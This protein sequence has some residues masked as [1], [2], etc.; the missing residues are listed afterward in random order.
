MFRGWV[1]S[2]YSFLKVRPRIR[3]RVLWVL[4]VL[5]RASHI[6]VRPLGTRYPAPGLAP[7]TDRWAE[8]TSAKGFAI[9]QVREGESVVNE[10]PKGLPRAIDSEFLLGANVEVPPSY[11]LTLPQGRVVGAHGAVVT[12]DNF[13]LQDLSWPVSMLRTSLLRE[14]DEIPEP[15]EF[16]RDSALPPRHLPGR[17][18]V[19]ST[20]FGRT[21]FHWMFDVI[22][23]LGVLQDAGIE[24]DSI[25]TFVVP[26][27]FSG[28]HHETLKSVGITRSRIVSSLRNRHVQADLLLA[29]S[30]T[31]RNGVVPSWV[32]D[33][34]R[35]LFPPS[36]P[37]HRD[38]PTRIYITRKLT[39]HGLLQGEEELV[40]RLAQHG[41]RPV[42]MEDYSL[43][44]KAWLLGR[45]EAV[46]GPSG[47][48]L[49]NIVFCS[50][51]TKVVELR[52]QPIP[53]MEPWDIANRC[54]I[55]F[56]EV[57]PKGYRSGSGQ[58]EVDK[59]GFAAQGEV[60]SEELFQTLEMADLLGTGSRR[61]D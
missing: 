20:F 48:G 6:A 42:A 57:M 58:P 5:A 56:Y 15:E 37:V 18:A 61:G 34:L 11:L 3:E 44:E 1:A 24:L 45:A 10:P 43:R 8:A 28:F 27:Y 26:G 4:T 32:V 38:R 60:D 52:V 54:G 2:A 22:P 49:A 7:D 35:R 17:V 53:I 21:Y 9:R 46:I 47:A 41:F 31:R 51:G 39:D 14:Q 30:L 13:L 19:L 16:F 33:I 50:P 23:R 36:E 25:D 29:T 12:P 55:D 40:D 59:Y